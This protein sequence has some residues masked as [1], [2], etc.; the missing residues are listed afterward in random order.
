MFVLP[1]NPGNLNYL[2]ILLHWRQTEVFHS[3]KTNGWFSSEPV[4]RILNLATLLTGGAAELALARAA[5]FEWLVD[6][7][8]E[9]T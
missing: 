5:A 3:R 9:P 4:S 7:Y 2:Y 6:P 1:P 8:V